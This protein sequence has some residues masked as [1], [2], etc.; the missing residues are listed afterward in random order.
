MKEDFAPYLK[1][2][3]PPILKMASLQ[4]SMGVAGGDALA[5]LVDVL[6]EVQ[7]V[8]KEGETEGEKKVSVHTDEIDEKDTA[9]QM[10]AVIIEE[11]GAGF[12]PYIEEASVIITSMLDFGN[13]DNIRSSAADTL[14][15]M[16]K[17]AK[18]A[19]IDQQSL[20]N[21]CKKYVTDISKA[22]AVEWETEVKISQITALKDII[23]EAGPGF[24]GQEEVDG[25][26]VSVIGL[27]DKSLDRIEQT[28]KEEK[29]L[30]EDS[31]E[32][33]DFAEDDAAMYKE[34]VKI[35]YEL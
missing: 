33:E 2:V 22:I 28:K 25:L 15:Y 24:Y 5:K 26:S 35:E 29:E 14:P 16:V 23:D 9:L 27:V 31:D 13:N 30:R 3:I 18:A 17:S 7:P 21:M 12:A 20:F 6:A 10:L 1:D 19:N 32:G 11:C 8:A 4:P 34:E